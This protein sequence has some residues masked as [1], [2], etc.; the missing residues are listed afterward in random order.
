M[1]PGLAHLKNQFHQQQ[2]LTYV[3]IVPCIRVLMIYYKLL[4][5]NMYN[6]LGFC[7]QICDRIKLNKKSKFALVEVW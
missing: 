3:D 2:I 4:S 1:R 5:N 6:P 7:L